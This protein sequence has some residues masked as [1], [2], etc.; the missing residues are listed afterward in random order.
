MGPGKRAV[1]YRTMN[2]VFDIGGTNMRVAAAEGD[3]L[4][5]V[6]KV[7]TPQDPKEGV[8]TLVQLARKLGGGSIGKA[9]G[10]VPSSI[11]SGGRMYDAESLPAWNGVHVAEEISRALGVPTR[12]LNDAVVV[13]LGEAQRGGGRG[14]S[15][16]AYLTVS[17]GV[18]GALIKSE[19]SQSPILQADF[20]ELKRNLNEQIS[21]TAVQKKFGIHPKELDSLEERNKLADILAAGLTEIYEKWKPDVFVLGGSM[22]VGVNPIPLERV[23]EKF[24]AVPVKMA[25]LGDNGGLIGGMILAQEL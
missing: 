14:F 1:F 20:E 15:S 11:D 24:T 7:P 17:T 19:V 3:T 4:G 5:E 21:G 9:A 12:V 13:G 16:V 2:I 25:E 6:R 22:I 8:T 23:R 18:G 10:D